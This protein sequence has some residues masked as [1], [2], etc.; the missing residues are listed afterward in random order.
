MRPYAARWLRYAAMFLLISPA[1]ARAVDSAAALIPDSAVLVVSMRAGADRVAAFHESAFWKRA[2]GS[3]LYETVRGGP[4]YKQLRTGVNFLQAMTGLDVWDAAAAAVGDDACLA[5]CQRKGDKPALLVVVRH[6]DPERIRRVEEVLKKIHIL[7]GQLVDE[8]PDAE[9]TSEFDGVTLWPS[10]NKVVH[11]FVDQTLILSNDRATLERSLKLR[12][13]GKS[14]LTRS[15]RFAQAVAAAPRDAP[16]WA[17]LDPRRLRTAGFLKNITGMLP[18]PLA[19]LLFSDWADQ[20]QSADSAVAWLAAPEGTRARIEARLLLPANASRPSGQDADDNA[21]DGLLAAAELPRGMAHLTL[22]RR[23]GDWW[24]DREKTM[25]PE[26]VGEFTKF[27]GVMTT[28]IAGL[29]F[30]E[31]F[32]PQLRPGV[33]L[34]IARQTFDGQ[35][36]PSPVLPAFALVMALRDPEKYGARLDSGATAALSVVNIQAAQ[37]GQPQY[38]VD[39]DKYRGHRVTF[40]KYPETA[41][42]PSTQ[43]AETPRRGVRFNFAPAITRVGDRVIIAT[44]LEMLHDIVDRIEQG[45]K[46]PAAKMQADDETYLDAGEIGRVLRENRDMFI[47]QQMLKTDQPRATVAKRVDA[48]LG[49]ADWFDHVTLQARSGR[50]EARISLEIGL[51][52]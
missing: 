26:A 51:K 9:K 29:D 31:E 18:N 22:H 52:P 39:I 47:T 13:G 32:L 42:Q 43:M 45:K 2:V 19:A 36:R 7:A 50:R 25:T 27:A 1:A 24:S 46:W 6:R 20:V 38:L 44:S 10:E 4:E 35:A 15:P 28:L 12:K 5:L 48:L 30:S 34:L 11:A 49:L 33:Q 41:S 16:I 8:K 17:M 21:I 40:T 3:P 37:N 14:A 23:F